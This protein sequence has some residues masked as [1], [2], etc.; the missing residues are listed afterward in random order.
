LRKLSQS[1]AEG[2]KVRNC[3]NSAADCPISIKF[4]TEF[5]QMFKVRLKVEVTGSEFKVI[6]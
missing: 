1:I 3:N 4:G 2:H 5:D 6:A